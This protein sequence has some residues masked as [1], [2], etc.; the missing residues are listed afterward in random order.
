M[1]N[2]GVK[3][4]VPCH[5]C[6]E[7]RPFREYVYRMPAQ[8]SANVLTYFQVGQYVPGTLYTIPFEQ[9]LSNTIALHYP[10]Y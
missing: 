5:T 9:W 1:E 8:M 3:M 4:V 10:L 6:R 7:V 2:I